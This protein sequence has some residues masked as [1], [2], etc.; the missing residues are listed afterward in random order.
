MIRLLGVCLVLMAYVFAQ[1]S[2]PTVN[3]ALMLTIPNDG[4]PRLFPSPNGTAVA[5]ERAVRL[6]GHRDYYLCI[7]KI[8]N[9][10]PQCSLIP[11]QGAR[12]FEPDPNSTFLPMSWSPDG[13]HIAVV[14]QPLLS[15]TD[16][17]LL[18]YELSSDTW[19]NLTDEG[20]EGELPAT[21]TLETQATWS[22]DSNTIAVE[23]TTFDEAGNKTSSLVL[24]N[25]QHG[26]AQELAL[27]LNEAG[28]VG[29]MAW[30]PDG[31]TLALSILQRTRDPNTDGVYLID[32]DTGESSRLIDIETIEVAFQSIYADVPLNLL[33]T[34]VWAPENSKL[35]FWAGNSDK[36]PMAVWAFVVN[37]QDATTVTPISLPTQ[38]SDKPDKRAL[39]PLQATWSPDGTTLLVLVPR[40]DKAVS[41]IPLDPANDAARV[42]LYLID[43]QSNTST[44]F[45]HLPLTA[46][47]G[48]YPATW[49]AAGDVIING[50][51][52]HLAK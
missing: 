10:E 44:L 50:Y 5:F 25:V 20:Y 27:K 6:N 8:T 48:M 18:V 16:S 23:R 31:K 49:S 39:R 32:V 52:L 29:G 13:L 28:S 42:S 4:S 7:L 24:V 40:R 38:T 30:S 41:E 14:G 46:S 34:L 17:D 21:V 33:G 35:M 2:V 9:D 47:V 19:R 12:G 45:G 1:T 37:V 11:Q 36:K 3:N 15:Q 51:A 22:L 26:E 43:V